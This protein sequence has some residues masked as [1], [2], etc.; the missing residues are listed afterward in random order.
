MQ[1]LYFVRLNFTTMRIVILLLAIIIASCSKNKTCYDC[2]AADSTGGTYKEKV[3]TD[4]DPKAKLP[5]TDANGNL[6]WHCTER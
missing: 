1:S 4:G 2:Q 3:C 6:V 5:R